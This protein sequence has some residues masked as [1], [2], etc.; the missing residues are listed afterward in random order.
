MSIDTTMPDAVWAKWAD[1][2]AR[3]NALAESR[4]QRLWLQPP[5]TT[6]APSRT[7]NG[8]GQHIKAHLGPQVGWRS[9]SGPY[10]CRCAALAVMRLLP[11]PGCE[12]MVYE[13]LRGEA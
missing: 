3:F 2:S 7:V 12:L 1:L 13:M 5:C 10:S 11:E 9:V 6:C 4:R 8:A